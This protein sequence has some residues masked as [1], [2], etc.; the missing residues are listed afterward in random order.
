MG[1]ENPQK[2]KGRYINPH[3]QDLKRTLW[4]FVLWQS[5]FYNEQDLCKN[6]PDGFSYPAESSAFD[7]AQ[8]TSAVWLGHSTYLVE[9]HGLSFLTDPLF[10]SHCSPVPFSALKRQHPAPL[11]IA[12]LP[13]LNFI[14]LSH[15]HYDHLDAKSMMEIHRRFPQVMFIVPRGV[16]RWFTRRGIESVIEMDWGSSYQRGGL[17]ITAVP[18]QHFSGRSFWDKNRTL[19]CGYVVEYKGKTFYFA[20]D[21]G[22]NPIQ[23]KEIGERWKSIDLSLIPIGT[24]VPKVFMQPVHI[25]PEEAVKIHCDVGSKLSLGMHW[26]TFLLS[27]EPANRPP[28]DLYLAMQERRLAFETFLPIEPGELKNW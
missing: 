17:C 6:P 13:Q 15:N 21:T 3:T 24:Y 28:Y 18:A 1:F 2:K 26:K 5:G 9:C 16:K 7:P 10:S 23:F 20:G 22:Y 19:W 12:D 25:N 11:A 14:L 8:P 4:D 27:D